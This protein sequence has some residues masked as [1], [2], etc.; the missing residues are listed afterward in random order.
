MGFYHFQ[1]LINSLYIF[2]GEE[3]SRINQ[4][5]KNNKLMKNGILKKV[6]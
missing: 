1:G 2:V 6:L 3:T 5:S 4:N